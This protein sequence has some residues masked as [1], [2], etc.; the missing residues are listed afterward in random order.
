MAYKMNNLRKLRE[1]LAEELWG[2][3]MSEVMVIG[4]EK[5][6]NSNVAPTCEAVACLLG[7]VS[8]IKSR[9]KG[10]LFRYAWSAGGKTGREDARHFLGMDHNEV[11]NLA[12]PEGYSVGGNATEK[13]QRQAAIMLLDDMLAE[14]VTYVEKTWL[15]DYLVK[16][17]KERKKCRSPVGK[18]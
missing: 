7:T 6:F 1:A 11:D 5:I 13:E 2:F 14:R 17:R 4:K 12:K 10:V 8:L 9:A 16:V 3:D 15:N 18:N